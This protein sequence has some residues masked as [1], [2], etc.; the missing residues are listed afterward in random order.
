MVIAG[1]GSFIAPSPG[2]CT[3]DGVNDR[4]EP[5]SMPNG[6]VDAIDVGARKITVQ[7]EFFARPQW[8]VETKIY[9]GGALKKVHHHD[10]SA[11]PEE[12]LQRAIERYHERKRQDLLDNL[13]SLRPASEPHE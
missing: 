2:A 12:D 1:A 3:I 5:D 11:T 4:G 8:R 10:L 7:T 9:V 13:R 6:R